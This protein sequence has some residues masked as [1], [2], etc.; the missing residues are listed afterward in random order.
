M[1]RILILL[2]IEIFNDGIIRPAITSKKFHCCTYPLSIEGTII[3]VEPCER[4]FTDKEGLKRIGKTRGRIKNGEEGQW[5][6]RY[7]SS[8]NAQLAFLLLR[9]PSLP[10]VYENRRGNRRILLEGGKKKILS[11]YGI[12]RDYFFFSLFF[13][14]SFLSLSLF[15]WGE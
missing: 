7:C 2:R 10:V 3:R 4:G 13:F 11:P 9:A 6:S 15:S 14:S 5:P 8:P 12:L 1:A